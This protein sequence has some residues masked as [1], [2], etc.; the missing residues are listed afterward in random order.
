[1]PA[2]S[3]VITSVLVLAVL[4]AVALFVRFGEALGVERSVMVGPGLT[5]STRVNRPVGFIVEHHAL[6]GTTTQI[7]WG[8]MAN[9]RQSLA[10]GITLPTSGSLTIRWGIGQTVGINAGGGL[11]PMPTQFVAAGAAPPSVSYALMNLPGQPS[12]VTG[13][14]SLQLGPT[15]TGRFDARGLVITSA[16]VPPAAIA[17]IPPPGGVT[18]ADAR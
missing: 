16:G 12:S 9:S 17:P 15:Y 14:M 11:T 5:L 6:D 1:M 18:G 13:N 3:V 2:R 7:A 4:L 10:A 8:I